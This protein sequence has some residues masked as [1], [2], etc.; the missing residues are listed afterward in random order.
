MCL[1]D[2]QRGRGCVFRPVGLEV[3]QR[4]C[5]LCLWCSLL[6]EPLWSDGA[7]GQIGASCCL[8]RRAWLEGCHSC[9][10]NNTHTHRVSLPPLSL[11]LSRSALWDARTRDESE[12][13]PLHHLHSLSKPNGRLFGN[14]AATRIADAVLWG[15][16]KA[17]RSRLRGWWR[18]T[19]GEG[20]RREGRRGGETCTVI[21]IRLPA[22]FVFTGECEWRK[23]TWQ[24]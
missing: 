1:I 12:S 4:R 11:S 20:G 18:I 3:R 23:M 10:E 16:I 7:L 5:R 8:E 2:N 21:S 22:P 19:E 6:Q 9:T 17:H 24:R 14:L 15:I 13:P